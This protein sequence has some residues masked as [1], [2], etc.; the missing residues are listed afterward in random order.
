MNFT[1][2]LAKILY[3][4]HEELFNNNKY[5]PFYEDKASKKLTL[6]ELKK[7]REFVDILGLFGWVFLGDKASKKLM[8]KEL[9]ND[10]EFVDI[11]D[12][13]G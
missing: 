5:S 2:I 1:L 13:F 6:K 10:R 7:D 12:L 8:L 3:P 11:L 4:H 9:K